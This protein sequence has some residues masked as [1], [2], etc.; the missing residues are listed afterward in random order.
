MSE[1]L[2][3]GRAERVCHLE[4]HRPAQ[5]NALSPELMRELES[6]LDAADSDPDIS[7]ILLSG[8]EQAF[9]AGAD[10]GR[11]A[12]W[13]YQQVFLDDYV[14]RHWE[15][16][17]S[18]RKPLIAAVRG[19]AIGGGCELAM[20]CDV[21]IAGE[22]ARFGQP[23]VKL[24]TLPGM[25]GTQRLPR[26]IGKAKAMEWCLSGQLYSAVE[27]ER[28]GLVSRVVADAEV[29]AT[30]QALA[31]RMAGYSL[32]ALMLIKESLNRAFESSL[33]EGLLFERRAFHA[34]FSLADRKEGMQAFLDKRPPQFQ[35]R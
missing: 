24:G 3:E 28:A 23:E 31:A 18:V 21:I 5:H 10:I 19:L 12:E 34:S 32:P 25:G 8:T 1:H 35:H 30:A 27:A 17:R 14:S 15:R 16:A 11:M 20:M 22:S 29:L 6:A 9:A 13:D 4:I 26:A 2:R 33:A 7:V